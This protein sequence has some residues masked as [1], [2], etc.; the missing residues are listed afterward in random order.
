MISTARARLLVISPWSSGLFLNTISRHIC[1]VGK[2]GSSKTTGKSLK[3]DQPILNGT[4]NLKTRQTKYEGR[5]L[6]K[7]LGCPKKI[8]APMVDG[9]D[10][11]WT[12]LSRRYG[13]DLCYS[14]ILHSMLFAEQEN[15]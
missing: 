4:E 11:A 7:N 5:E 15:F 2:M 1:T 13:A 8:V 14:P 12:I 6:Y 9:S 3:H 10:L